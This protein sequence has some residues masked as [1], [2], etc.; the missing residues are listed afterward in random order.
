[1]PDDSNSRWPPGSIHHRVEK[2]VCPT[3]STEAVVL[4]AS[5]KISESRWTPWTV[6]D[7][8]LLPAGNIF[9]HG[10]CTAQL[11]APQPPQVSSTGTGKV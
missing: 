4:A 11:G 5:W 3:E 7:C 2:V 9:C 8:S 10:P 1:M 6:V